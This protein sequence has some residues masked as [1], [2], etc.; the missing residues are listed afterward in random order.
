MSSTTLT[1]EQRVAKL[2]ERLEPVLDK[3]DGFEKL[4][5]RIKAV[6]KMLDVDGD[7]PLDHAKIREEFEKNRAFRE[8]TKRAIK[9]RRDGFYAS[10]IEEAPFNVTKALFGWS[11]GRGSKRGFEEA[12]AMAEFEA[13]QECL[14]AAEKNYSPAVLKASGITVGNTESAASLIADQLLGEVIPDVYSQSAFVNLNGQGDGRTR[15]RV[16]DGLVG[17][18]QKLNGFQRGFVFYWVGAGEDLTQ[19]KFKTYEKKLAPHKMG[20][21]TSIDED[22][23]LLAS[24]GFDALMRG[25]LVNGASEEIDRVI[26]FGAG[27]REPIGI[28]NTPGVQFYSAEDGT[29]YTVGSADL[30]TINSGDW[31]GAVLDFD[32]LE[33]LDLHMAEAKI[34]PTAS[35]ATISGDRYFSQLKRLKVENYSTQTTGQPYLLG[36]PMLSDARLRE[37][38]G[39]F[40]R[41]QLD[42][43]LPTKPGASIGAPSATGTANCETVV[44]GNM[45][46]VLFARW[47]GMEITDDR[48][49][50]SGFPS[51]SMLVKL[52]M[53]ADVL[54]REVRALRFCPDAQVA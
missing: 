30:S 31:Q 35:R 39:D 14:R 7:E 27:G 37:L 16:V 26:A 1:T 8:E 42:Q 11:R 51:G 43:F 48:G 33:G 47:A 34:R 5:D 49:L 54:V 17:G 25:D 22:M 10:G 41:S 24:P 20:A 45:D 2:C 19:S 3:M 28:C 12:G 21:L 4:D 6:E 13:M 38:I 36:M 52:V 53:R 50:G 44:R 32:G 15:V 23:E 46:E 29:F 18:E 40:G 9:N